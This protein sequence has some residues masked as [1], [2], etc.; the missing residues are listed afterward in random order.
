MVGKREAEA[1]EKRAKP[2]FERLYGDS[3]CD[4]GIDSLPS[5]LISQGTGTI[6]YHQMTATYTSRLRQSFNGR[7]GS[8]PERL[9]QFR[10]SRYVESE[11]DVS[12]ERRTF[13]LTG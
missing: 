5:G 2:V 11:H 4:E 8:E 7:P 13:R 10:E 6:V 9:M 1:Y 3:C 12:T